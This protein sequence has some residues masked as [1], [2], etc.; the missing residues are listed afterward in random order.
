MRWSNW[1][2][3][4]QGISTKE[5]WCVWVK[6]WNI[7]CKNTLWDNTKS[8]CY[9]RRFGRTFTNRSRICW[10]RCDAISHPTSLIYWTLLLSI[11]I[12]FCHWPWPIL[13]QPRSFEDVQ[14]W[15]NGWIA[16][17]YMEFC[18]LQLYVFHKSGNLW[19]IW[20]IKP[21]IMLVFLKAKITYT[22]VKQIV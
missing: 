13:E 1:V 20:M 11:T 8:F 3:W 6:Q 7:I 17:K 19:I 16:S 21:H 2:K 18:R 4:W 9:R 5:K 12:C 14:K 22:T 10:R 15:T